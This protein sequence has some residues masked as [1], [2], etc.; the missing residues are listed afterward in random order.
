MITAIAV[1]LGLG[2]T[3]EVIPSA[4]KITEPLIAG[5][6]VGTIAG[7][8]ATAVGVSGTVGSTSVLWV[9][10]VAVGAGVTAAGATAYSANK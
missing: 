1:I 10:T 3:G 7:P 6:A 9:D 8:V 2:V 4:K 5:V